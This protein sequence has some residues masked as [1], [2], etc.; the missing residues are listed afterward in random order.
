MLFPVMFGC[1]IIKF[2]NKARNRKAPTK[3]QFFERSYLG[4]SPQIYKEVFESSNNN[5]EF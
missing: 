3:S 1:N 4:G 2:N 5:V